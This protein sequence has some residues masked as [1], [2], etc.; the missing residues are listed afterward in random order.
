MES[1]KRIVSTKTVGKKRINDQKWSYP[2]LLPAVL[3]VCAIVVI[4]FVIGIYYSFTKWD[5]ISV[6]TFVGLENFK[7][8][9]SDK[10]FMHS[11]WFTIK[12][13]VVTV[14]LINLVGLGLVLIVTRCFR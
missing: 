3:A 7:R 12:F 11:L 2:F 1:S 14:A 13:S 9:L 10:E 4:P 8:I 6:S 5:G